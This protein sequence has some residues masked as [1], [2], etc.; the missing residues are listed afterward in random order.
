MLYILLFIIVLIITWFV[1]RSDNKTKTKTS[2]PV[3]KLIQTKNIEGLKKYSKDYLKDYILLRQKHN[4]NSL[5][6]KDVSNL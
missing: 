2:H 6:I 3:I 1:F 5:T 4:L